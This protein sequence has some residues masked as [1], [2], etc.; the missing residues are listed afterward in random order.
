[1]IDED[2]FQKC[3][4]LLN[5]SYFSPTRKTAK[6]KTIYKLHVGDGETLSYFLFLLLPYMGKRRKEQI[7]KCIDAIT[8]WENWISAGRRSKMAREGGLK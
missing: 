2:I 4:K 8:E 1:M 7:E 6:N 3:A 5:K